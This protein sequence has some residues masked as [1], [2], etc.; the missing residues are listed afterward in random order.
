METHCARGESLGSHGMIIGTNVVI[1]G[2]KHIMILGTQQ[3]R[4]SL[5]I[6][7]CMQEQD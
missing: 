5:C 4:L 7:G 1:L 2:S 3:W 6:M